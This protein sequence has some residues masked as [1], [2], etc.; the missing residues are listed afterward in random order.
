MHNSLY[1][2][3]HT[4]IVI[5]S[6]IARQCSLSKDIYL[7]LYNEVCSTTLLPKTCQLKKKGVVKQGKCLGVIYNSVS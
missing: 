5:V 3:E 1:H 4:Q 6:Y 7:I 2:R